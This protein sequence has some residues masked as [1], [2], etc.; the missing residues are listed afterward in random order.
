MARGSSGQGWFKQYEL[1]GPDSFKKFPPP[2]PF[3]WSRSGKTCRAYF[4][5][6]IGDEAAGRVEMELLEQLLPV[7]VANFASLCSGDNARGL[8]YAGTPVHRVVKGAALVAGDVEGL[9]GAGSHSALTPEQAAAAKPIWAGSGGGGNPEWV[10]KAAAAAAAEGGVGGGEGGGGGGGGGLVRYFDDEAFLVP[11][12][13]EGLLSMVNGG[14]HTNGSQ[15]YITTAP[16]PH[17]DGYSVAFGRV[18]SGMDVVHR[19][20]KVFSIRGKPVE[21]IVISAA[22][23]H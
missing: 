5:V 12:S 7:T 21:P 15:F 1:E 22:G 2:T 9:G 23:L 17:L 3:D 8:C 19:A 16:A 11:H 14:V 18:V 4:D 13:E 20:S 6:A 10:M